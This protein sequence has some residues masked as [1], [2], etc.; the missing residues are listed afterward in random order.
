MGLITQ[1]FQNGVPDFLVVDGTMGFHHKYFLENAGQVLAVKH[2]V[3]SVHP[4]DLDKY[5][6]Y[7]D[8]KGGAPGASIYVTATALESFSKRKSVYERLVTAFPDAPVVVFDSFE[9][10]RGHFTLSRPKDYYFDFTSRILS[11]GNM[12]GGNGRQ[13]DYETRCLMSRRAREKK[14]LSSFIHVAEDSLV[15]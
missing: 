8:D 12:T 11:V 7:L 14:F 4:S 10:L 1:A 2:E 13:R 15:H 5:I 3:V 9:E 6:T